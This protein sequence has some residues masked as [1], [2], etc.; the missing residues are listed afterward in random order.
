MNMK[1]SILCVILPLSLVFTSLQTAADTSMANINVTVIVTANNCQIN[2]N[3]AVTV[4]FGT[5]QIS[6]LSEATADVPVT[7]ACDE[8]PQGTLSMAI[9]GTETSF[10][11]QALQT[12]IT[13]L[14]ITLD[15]P[16][17]KKLDLN[18]YYDVGSTFG[19]TG[20]NGSFNLVAHLTSDG[21]TELASGEFNASAT[22]VIQVS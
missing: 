16:A 10:N 15:S 4:E 11:A 8:E 3:Q 7:I 12:D 17:S 14:G 2:A 19:L 22:L 13:G 5:V 20:K 9:K 21:K 1:R 6:N 18:T